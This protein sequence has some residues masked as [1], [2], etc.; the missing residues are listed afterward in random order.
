MQSTTLEKITHLLKLAAK[1]GTPGEAEAALQGVSRL[2]S[3]FN[4]SQVEIDRAQR[5]DGT[6]GVRIRVSQDDIHDEV[7]H[8]ASNLTRWDKTIGGAISLATNTGRYISWS[9]TLGKATIRLYGL[10]E[11][12]EVARLLFAFAREAM[13]RCARNWKRLECSGYASALQTRTFKD[14]FTRGL[15]DAARAGVE[16]EKVEVEVGSST[17]LVLVSDITK[18]KKDALAIK[19]R[20]LGLTMGRRGGART[21]SGCGA[22]GAG[23]A[24][25][26]STSLAS[27]KRVR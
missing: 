5:A 10:R 27:M 8:Y 23:R 21:H 2:A 12:I 17:A 14:G 19:S 18:A 13:S 9:R 16:T 1:A 20:A 24:A 26:R 4:I 6:E 3:K 22:Y 11:D 15:M 7:I 25:G